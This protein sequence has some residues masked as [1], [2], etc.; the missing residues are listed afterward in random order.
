MFLVDGGFHFD[1]QRE[2]TCLRRSEIEQC[3]QRIKD[4]GIRNVVVSGVFSPVNKSQE[5]QVPVAACHA[6]TPNINSTSPC[7]HSKGMKYSVFLVFVI[8]LASV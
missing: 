6:A 7:I 8:H 5:E 4:N 2:I 1:G 3:V